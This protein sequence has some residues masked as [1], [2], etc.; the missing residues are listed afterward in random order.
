MKTTFHPDRASLGDINHHP[1]AAAAL[2]KHTRA[3]ATIAKIEETRSRLA[4]EL[5][6]AKEACRKV[7]GAFTLSEATEAEIH[8]ARKVV[9]EAQK[10]LSECEASCR[11]QRDG[12][13][14][15]AS[16]VEEAREAAGA[17][18]YG[19]L[20][21]RHGRARAAFVK[22]LKAAE[23]ARA[24]VAEVED[25]LSGFALSKKYRRP[26]MSAGNWLNGMEISLSHRNGHE[27]SVAEFLNEVQ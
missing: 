20:A 12:L 23:A 17:E 24:E 22:A 4:A 15:L 27:R 26:G 10:A 18:I 19:A 11:P 6:E 21:D 9:A 2:E 16:R 14:I 1:A 3:K 5:E 7:E 13:A 8:S 25:L